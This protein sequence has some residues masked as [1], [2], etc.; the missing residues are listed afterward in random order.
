MEWAVEAQYGP[1]RDSI[2]VA[3]IVQNVAAPAN[4]KFVYAVMMN[5]SIY[6]MLIIYL[7]HTK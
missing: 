2:P 1:T 7:D 6:L 5:Y 3:L 4:R